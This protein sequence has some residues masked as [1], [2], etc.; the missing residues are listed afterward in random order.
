MPVFAC[1]RGDCANLATEQSNCF[2]LQDALGKNWLCVQTDLAKIP[3]GLG[4]AFAD[5][6]QTHEPARKHGLVA[7]GSALHM[8]LA[9]KVEDLARQLTLATY[10]RVA[11]SAARLQQ[12]GWLQAMRE[13]FGPDSP[14]R[15]WVSD[16]RRTPE[17]E[18]ANA[19]EACHRVAQKAL[20][21]ESPMILPLQPEPVPLR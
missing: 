18:G 17:A 20:Q 8:M 12:V 15:V 5:M 6:L 4:A 21:E 14:V 11:Q 10:P 13:E 9:D 3:R 16:G 1:Y 2:V 19:E 7:E